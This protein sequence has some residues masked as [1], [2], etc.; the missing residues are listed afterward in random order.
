MKGNQQH[1]LLLQMKKF[2]SIIFLISNGVWSRELVKKIKINSYRWLAEEAIHFNLDNAEFN[3][4]YPIIL[5][6]YGAKQ[7]TP[8]KYNKALLCGTMEITRKCHNPQQGYR[9]CSTLFS[10]IFFLV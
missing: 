4:N 1:P 10:Q 3:F 8:A 6:W 9:N 5:Q 2:P 7:T